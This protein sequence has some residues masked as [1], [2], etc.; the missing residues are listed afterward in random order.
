MSGTEIVFMALAFA[1]GF[2]AAW[3]WAGRKLSEAQASRASQQSAADELRKQIE[4]LR[5]DADA[6]RQ[7]AEA[8]QR[9]RVAAETSLREAAKNLDEQRKAIEEAHERMKDAFS[10][11]A[12]AALKSS[13]EDFIRLAAESFGK[14]KAEATGDLSKRQQAIQNLVE[15]LNKSLDS[16][17]HEL[18]RVEESR[19]KAYGE[20]STQVEA[21]AKSSQE[22]RAETGSLVT[23]LRQPQTKGKWGELT[24]RRAVELAGMTQH[25]D[26]VEQESVETEE[27]RTLRPDMIVKLVG[28]RSILVDAKVPLHAYWKIDSIRNQDEY[29][30]VLKEH[31]RLVRNH[32]NNLAKKNYGG[33]F[34]DATDFVVLFLPGESFFSAALQKDPELIADAMEKRVVL[35][36]PTTLIALLR[37]IAYGWRQAELA[38]NAQRISEIGKDLYERIRVFAELLVKVGKSLD[39]V[40][41]AYGETVGSFEGRLVPGARKFRELGVQATAELPDV[42]PTGVS[43]RQLASSTTEDV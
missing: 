32:V 17:Q 12:S 7:R 24:L 38:E 37:A 40:N 13:N 19:Q 10:S 33:E 28:N 5:A 6:A 18:T 16:L 42:E 27:G 36:S 9:G 21:L 8:E 26:F 3:L 41:K 15:P 20:L 4:T 30:E 1:A 25:V 35:A 43:V 14:L 11:L 23:S 34:A 2:A 31:A 22:L 39:S 29:H